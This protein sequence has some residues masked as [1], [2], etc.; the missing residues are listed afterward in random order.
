MG[1][2]TPHWPKKI[3]GAP[4]H[5]DFQ[6]PLRR[7][8]FGGEIGDRQGRQRRCWCNPAIQ[9]NHALAGNV[10]QPMVA[11]QHSDVVRGQHIHTTARPLE[12]NWVD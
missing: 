12:G 1:I 8:F 11:P 2:E 6:V 7:R 3:A 4:V 9:S 10:D 5:I